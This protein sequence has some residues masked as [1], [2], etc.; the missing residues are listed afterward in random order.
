VCVGARDVC[1]SGGG[2]N[3]RVLW[4]HPVRERLQQ[5]IGFYDRIFEVFTSWKRVCCRRRISLD[6]RM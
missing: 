1:R 5:A 2:R 6:R 4:R 3:P